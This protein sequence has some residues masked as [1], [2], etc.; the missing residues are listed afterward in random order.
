M[1]FLYV[2]VPAIISGKWL[3]FMDPQKK[4]WRSD[5]GHKYNL[6]NNTPEKE[7]YK[8][9][10]S[11]FKF[12][13]PCSLGKQQ[14]YNGT[15]IRF[16]LRN[17]PSGLSNKL[18]TVAKL[19]EL[20]QA[21]KY[22]A[23][24]LLLFLRY[25]EK[26]VVFTINKSSLVTE[27]FSIEIDKATENQR[28]Q[29][30]ATFLSEVEKYHATFLS[31][32]EK[33]HS[34]PS[35]PLPHLQYEATIIVRD[36]QVRTRADYKWT[37]MHWVGSRDKDVIEASSK[38]SNLPWIGLAVPLTLQCPSRL[39]CFQTVKRLIHHYQFVFMVPLG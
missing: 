39:F 25:V 21:L 6:S 15:L 13:D 8:D 2:D 36:V 4:M 32:V 3:C 5:P 24:I 10:F 11:P 12:T 38:V 33:Y 20:L 22:D 27:C 28:R 29:L 37:I 16:P 26:I 23:A 17:E 1:S 18:Y 9:S 14:Q 31:E 35:S 30:K 19:K 7:R 34:I